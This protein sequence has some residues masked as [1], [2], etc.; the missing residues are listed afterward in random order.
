MTCGGGVSTH[1]RAGDSHRPAWVQEAASE[2]RRPH[3]GLPTMGF[4]SQAA[5]G[6]GWTNDH[7]D[8]AIARL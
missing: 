7:S 6:P 5:L 4:A 8:R 3:T 1:P 2:C